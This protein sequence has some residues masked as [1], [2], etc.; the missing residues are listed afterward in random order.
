MI[1]YNKLKKMSLIAFIDIGA[2]LFYF[3][4]LVQEFRITLSVITLP[5]LLYIYRELK[6][7]PTVL[8]VGVISILGRSLFSALSEYTFIEAFIGSYP[9]L[10]FY[11]MYGVLYQYF[12]NKF[13]NFDYT[14][15]FAS[16][17]MCDFLGNTAEIM[18]RALITGNFEILR[19][20]LTLLL[21]AL[22]RGSI[23]FLIIISINY[24]HLLLKRK[25]HEERYKRLLIFSS[26]IESEIY[27]MNMNIDFI[28]K[29][30]SNSYNLYEKLSKEEKLKK[31]GEIALQI[32]KEVHEV[33]K[34]YIGVIEG[35]E[36][37]MGKRIEKRNMNFSDIAEILR[38]II[39]SYINKNNL[40]IDLEFI[41]NDDV[42]VEKHYYV[43]SVLRNLLMN[44]IESIGDKKG[45]VEMV[46]DIVD[47]II[48]LR[49]IDNGEGIKDKNLDYIFHPGFS[50]KFNEDS[51]DIKRGIGL[52]LVKDIVE[53]E[54]KGKIS[55]TS[56]NS[57]TEFKIEIPISRGEIE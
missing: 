24:Y 20:T 38:D 29:V 56:K 3:D 2:S 17:V 7:L 5:V 10:G 36:D 30:M 39:T 42:K 55:V 43:M 12:Y 52:T 40:D 53:K 16:I 41:V 1:N 6:P 47:D 8:Y 18:T 14:Y 13:K 25:E 4:Y 49:V 23:A 21:I 50:T 28:E 9:E 51:G 11:F 22:I 15:W 46:F 26:E 35:I 27:Y 37:I 54:F 48:V 32:A 44:A 33:K 34:N 19:D 57:L 45:M 31:E